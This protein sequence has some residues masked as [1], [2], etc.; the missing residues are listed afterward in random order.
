M[1]ETSQTLSEISSDKE[2]EIS[3][4]TLRT[5]QSPNWRP[6]WKPGQSGNPTGKVPGSKNRITA[7]KLGIEESL[8][9]QLNQYMP[10]I[11]QAAVEKALNGDRVMQMFLLGL[12]ISKPAAVEDSNSG[13]EKVKVTI[14]NLT[15][16]T[17][18]P[19]PI[20]IE[21]KVLNEQDEPEDGR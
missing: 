14:R 20:Q 21:G 18:A 4:S 10:E 12:C 2:S 16:E 17:K 7:Q 1:I 8:R 9:G 11:L 19:E 5:K 15:L 6:P 3:P 13:K